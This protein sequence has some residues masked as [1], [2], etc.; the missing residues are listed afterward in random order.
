MENN[1]IRVTVS[2]FFQIK[3]ADIFGGAGSIGYSESKIDL[4][5]ADLSG[6]KLQ[7]Y[8]KGQIEGFAELLKTPT[9]NIRIISRQEYED[10]IEED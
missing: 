7:E 3:D 2:L 5:A 8:A 1:K 10:N 4:N 6:F 9:E